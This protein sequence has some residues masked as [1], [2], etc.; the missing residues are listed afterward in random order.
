MIPIVFF[1]HQSNNNYNIEKNLNNDSEIK[2]ITKN[3]KKELAIELCIIEMKEKKI[4]FLLDSDT[5]ISYNSIQ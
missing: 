5:L 3:Y 2:N 1:L 4:L